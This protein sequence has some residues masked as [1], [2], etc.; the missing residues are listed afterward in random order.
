MI[1]IIGKGWFGVADWQGKTLMLLDVAEMI[2][3]FERDCRFCK[4]TTPFTYEKIISN[5]SVG[6]HS[7]GRGSMRLR[8]KIQ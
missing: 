3:H 5:W 4:T 2:G 1:L 6:Y 7:G 8:L